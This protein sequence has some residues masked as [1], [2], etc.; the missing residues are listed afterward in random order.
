[1]APL[2]RYK[3]SASSDSL[4]TGV[5]ATLFF[6]GETRCCFVPV[7][8]VPEGFDV[9]RATVLELQVVSVFPHVQAQDWEA[10]YARDRFTHQRGVLVSGRNH[11]Q[12][13]A[14][15][16]QP[17]PARTET[18]CSGF[19]KFRFEVIYGTEVALDSRFQIAL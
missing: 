9:V 15:Q 14:F 6:S 7:H 11:R 1:M 19:L 12:L 5:N 4:L 16:D 17:R 13:V 2:C 18:G 10:G 8:H 3:K